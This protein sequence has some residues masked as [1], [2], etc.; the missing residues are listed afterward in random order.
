MVAVDAVIIEVLSY[1]SMR[2]I[3]KGEKPANLPARVRTKGPLAIN[4]KTRQSTRINSSIIAA[5]ACRRG[6]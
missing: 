1:A 5:R 6:D 2:H 4:L 3:F